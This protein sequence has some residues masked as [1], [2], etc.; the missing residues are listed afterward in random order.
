MLIMQAVTRVGEACLRRG[1]RRQRPVGSSRRRL[2]GRLIE[3]LR[4]TRGAAAIEFAFVAPPFLL[5]LMGT[6]E[7]SLAFFT[8]SVIEGATK[9]AARQIR[10]GKVQE[11]ADPLATFRSELCDQ[12]FGIIDCNEVVFHVQTFSNFQS[13]SMPVELDEDGEIVNTAFT[14]GGSSAITV[15]R[16]MYRWN[17]TTPLIDKVMPAGLGGHLIV[18]TAAFQNEPYQFGGN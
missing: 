6:V 7:I 14:P 13:V 17:F 10:T 18:S 8:S 16:A 12:L 5:L 2:A 11:S 1:A 3:A 9:E 15:V 4:D